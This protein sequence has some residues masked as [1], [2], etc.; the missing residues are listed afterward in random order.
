[1]NTLRWLAIVAVLA[2]IRVLLGTSLLAVAAT[3]LA[4]FAVL[5]WIFGIRDWYR[6][7]LLAAG[8]TGL[9]ALYQSLL[10]ADSVFKIA[11]IVVLMA[12]VLVPTGLSLRRGR[13]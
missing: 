11:V 10:P 2:L 7:P 1:M 4:V 8:A 13:H 6:V 9:Y 12:S 3:F 5:H